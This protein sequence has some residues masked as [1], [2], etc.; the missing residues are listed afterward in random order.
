MRRLT[1]HPPHSLRTNPDLPRVPHR[2]R[3]PRIL[4]A[5][6]CHDRRVMHKPGLF[7]QMN[8]GFAAMVRQQEQRLHPDRLRTF[9]RFLEQEFTR[10]ATLGR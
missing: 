5:V 8:G 6:E 9:D 7:V 2:N 10:L 1:R 4:R 3:A